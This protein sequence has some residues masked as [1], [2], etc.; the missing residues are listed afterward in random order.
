MSRK[1]YLGFIIVLL[2]VL[3]LLPGCASNR[4]IATIDPITDLSTLKVLHVKK[5]SEDTRNTNVIIE[6]KLVDMGFQVSKTEGDADAIVTYIDK[7]FWDITFYMIELTVTLRDPK[8][9]FP[10]ASGNSYH[11][12]LTRRSPEGMVDEVLT[13]IFFSKQK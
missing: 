4:A 3:A 12:S 7:W 5:Y 13:N 9:D 2:A 1:N 10:L 8:N 6:K 11:T